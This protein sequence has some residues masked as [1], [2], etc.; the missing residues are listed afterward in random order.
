VEIISWNFLIFIT[1][2]I[3]VYY[4]LNRKT[5]NFWLVITSIFFFLTWGWPH[6][7][8]LLL[9]AS[10]TFFS[11][12]K[13]NN[14]NRLWLLTG[15]I[16]N[17]L[18]FILYRVINS[19][20]FNIIS[21]VSPST[22]T[23]FINQF[24]IPLG[25][26][27]YVLQAISYLI[28]VY[29]SKIKAETS[30]IDFFVYLMFFPKVLAGP[31]E[32][33]GTFLPQLKKERVVDNQKLARGFTLILIGL[34]RKMVIAEVLLS[35][36]PANYIH[37]P[38]VNTHSALGILSFPFF[39]Y[40]ESIPYANRLIGIVA[41]GIYLYNDFAGYTGIVRGISLLMGFNLVANF[42]TPYFSSSLSD[43]WSR[44]HISL[45]SW[46]RDYIYFPLTR[47]FKKKSNGQSSALP[48]IVPLLSTMLIS[49]FWHGMTIPLLLWGLIYGII[50]ILEQFAF[51][52]WPALRPQQQSR[53]VKIIAVILTFT[54]VT[55]AWV[56][57]TA[58]SVGEI[59]AFWKV[60]IKGSGWNSPANF[61][62]WILILIFVSF[63]LDF[64][65][66]RYQDEIFILKWPLLARASVLAVFILI[67]ILASTW[68]SQYVSKVF[69]YQGF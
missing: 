7:I 59:L 50:M 60:V 44:W 57:F 10:V 23:S 54:I 61:S 2:V 48:V 63:L 43:F 4:F 24:L 58:A 49:G 9:I 42:Q 37:A 30:I 52:K 28:D 32:R 68:T 14:E 40:A 65:Q 55:L 64:F 66:S 62:Y 51:Q 33:A 18:I 6:L 41:Y 39:T 21:P 26:S 13:L 20:L 31:I 34:F 3:I 11:G 1:I 45:S 27:F 56:P 19:P 25:F 15:I 38:I 36:L 12:K 5:Q 35:I 29:K 8:P 67:L 22:S 53:F 16:V 46:L 47:F 17:V 69:I